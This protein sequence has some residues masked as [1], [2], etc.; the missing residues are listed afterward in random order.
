MDDFKLVCLVMFSV[1]V[2]LSLLFGSL[3]LRSEEKVYGKGEVHSRLLV[4]LVCLVVGV[5]VGISAVTLTAMMLVTSPVEVS[6][7]K[8]P[9]L[10]QEDGLL[11]WQRENDD[12]I[13]VSII[14]GNTVK[15]IDLND[16]GVLQPLGIGEDPYALKT[17]QKLG[18]LEREGFQVYLNY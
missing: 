8:Y 16:S 18:F 3:W 2:V 13:R 1:C 11:I 15:S 12:T 7:E 4:R 10:E 17:I 5:T 14:D 9:L 6:Q